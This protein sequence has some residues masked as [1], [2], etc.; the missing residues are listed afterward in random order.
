MNARVSALVLLLVSACGGG[1]GGSGGSANN[2]SAPTP[3][4]P[5]DFTLSSSTVSFT[6][7]EGPAAAPAPQTISVHLLDTKAAALGAAYV[8]PQ[9]QPAWLTVAVTGTAPDYTVTL[10]ASATEMT[11][12]TASAV[13]TLGTADASG[14]VLTAKPVQIS[15]TVM[16]A[17]FNV[18]PAKVVIGGLDGLSRDPATLQ[19]SVP[20]PSQVQ[21]SAT[22]L[23]ATG[24]NW[25]SLSS[26]SGVVGPEG[27]SITVNGDRNLVAPGKYSGTIIL[28]TTIDG[29]AVNQYLP[30]T[31]NKEMH[32]LRVSVLGAAF[33][34]FPSRAVLT[35]TL[36]VTSTQ[37]RS[38][39]AWTATSDQ[40]WLSVTSGGQTGGDLVLTANP[41]GL[42]NNTVHIAT[43]RVTSAD[44]EIENEQRVRVGFW[45]SSSD[46]T[47]VTVNT[48]TYK[49][50][51]NPVEPYVYGYT[52]GNDI[53]AYNIY[54]GAAIATFHLGGQ[55]DGVAMSDDGSV[56]YVRDL[57]NKVV[58]ALDATSGAELRRYSY[59]AGTHSG[60]A[61]VRPN[62]HPV[63]ALADDWFIDVVTGVRV[64][65]RLSDAASH[66]DVRIV[67]HPNGR[68]LYY[69]N[70]SSTPAWV[71]RHSISYSALRSDG[72]GLLQ[73]RQ[74][75][76]DARDLCVSADGNK[77]Y[78]P[79]YTGGYSFRVYDAVTMQQLQRLPGAS[80]PNNAACAWNGLFVGGIS[81][82]PGIWIYRADGT[83]LSTL[84][85]HS[86]S[87]WGTPDHSLSLSGDNTRFA[88]PVGSGI[89]FRNLPSP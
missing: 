17:P 33:S 82:N 7:L 31:F 20:G 5:G 56:L 52:V 48:S 59:E 74:T 70:R 42:Q 3:I 63:L 41:V 77:V 24:G 69:V 45:V 16:P 78:T 11:T 39:V 40:P 28:Q 6:A 85:I 89:A 1:G 65:R 27:T 55:P 86:G 26:T 60:I 37:G 80:Y 81:G 54:S 22:T 32:A 47:D 2:S 12:G 68:H 46:P 44:P 57:T 73:G 51:A 58:L 15:L 88:I 30:V 34:S 72:L 49:L 36:Q 10:T 14:T 13:L 87:G 84:S 71:D 61:Y 9:T 29:R 76:D 25:L 50:I 62:A 67:A 75:M 66:R 53:T 18:S 19:F 35:R 21:W 38:D 23:T 83:L 79:D 43:V 4:S 64:Q 8:A